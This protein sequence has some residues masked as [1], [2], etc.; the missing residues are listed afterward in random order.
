MLLLL[1]VAGCSS[2]NGGPTALDVTAAQ[3]RSELGS[4]ARWP[5]D[6]G[7]SRDKVQ[8]I[9]DGAYR[10][11][12]DVHPDDT[13]CFTQQDRSIFAVNQAARLWRSY[14]AEPS[15]HGSFP[16]ARAH[17][18]LPDAFQDI[19]DYCWSTYV[20]AGKRDARMLGPC[21]MSAVGGDF[22]GVVP[23]A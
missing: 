23:V 1:L 14:L 22:F 18:N 10:F 11:C 15:K 9:R 5:L 8:A 7:L 17:Q 6:T 12:R 21:L 19:V 3:A 16:Y 13:K 2:G 4:T 20:D